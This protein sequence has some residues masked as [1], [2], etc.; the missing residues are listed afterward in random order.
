MG[1]R[2]TLRVRSREA[3]TVPSG[4]RAHGTR[5]PALL[6]ARTTGHS[7]VTVRCRMRRGER[8]HVPLVLPPSRPPYVRNYP[9]TAHYDGT[10]E[11]RQDKRKTARIAETSQLAGRFRRWWQVLGSNQ[12]RLSRRF[13]RPLPLATRATCLAPPEQAAQKIVA[14]DAPQCVR[15]QCRAERK[16]AGSAPAW[17]GAEESRVV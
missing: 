6:P 9:Y 10:N 12:R 11:T 3:T 2:G 8:L 1:T 17:P 13:Y 7:Y 16:R 5:D 14:Q 15:G 4:S